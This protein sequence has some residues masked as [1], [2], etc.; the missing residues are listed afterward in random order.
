MQPCLADDSVS[1]AGEKL[2]SEPLLLLCSSAAVCGPKALLIS[3]ASGGH[4]PLA[5]EL[6][7]LS[8]IPLVAFP[9]HKHHFPIIWTEAQ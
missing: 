7:K 6:S 9:A 4:A 3:L 5:D 8:S 1:N 2:S